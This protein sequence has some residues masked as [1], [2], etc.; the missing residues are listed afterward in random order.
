M[1]T[2]RQ[3]AEALQVAH[4]LDM[5]VKLPPHTND[6]ALLVEVQIACLESYYSNLR[7]LVE[8]LGLTNDKKTIK[9]I[10]FVPGWKYPTGQAADLLRKEYGFASEQVSHLAKSRVP[11][12]EG[13]I[14]NVHPMK[15]RNIALLV[16]R[17][18]EDEY[19]PALRAAGSP[20]LVQFEASVLQAKVNVSKFFR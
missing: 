10:D 8:F 1:T 9:A 11:D 7:V 4:A 12:A 20:Q 14:I 18:F 19:V 17:L 2:S 6:A 13:T 15:L 16:V 3:N 5:I